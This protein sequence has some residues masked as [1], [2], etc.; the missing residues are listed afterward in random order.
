MRVR[1][2]LPRFLFTY[3]IQIRGGASHL[4]SFWICLRQNFEWQQQREQLQMKTLKWMSYRECIYIYTHTKLR[5]S[6]AIVLVVASDCPLTQ[7][8]YHTNTP[9]IN[10]FTFLF[11]HVPERRGEEKKEFD[12]FWRLCLTIDEHSRDM[13]T[14]KLKSLQWYKPTSSP[15]FPYPSLFTYGVLLQ[16]ESLQALC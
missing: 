13:D 15:P 10:W 3:S 11:D 2:N 5:S 16:G 4:Q 8:K 9:P 12:R 14:N 6:I 7:L 1:H